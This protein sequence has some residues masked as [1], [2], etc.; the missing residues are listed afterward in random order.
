MKHKTAQLTPQQF[1]D[2]FDSVDM[3]LW[4]SRFTRVNNDG[5]VWDEVIGDYVDCQH[6]FDT[7]A[8][9]KFVVVFYKEQNAPFLGATLA[10]V[11]EFNSFAKTY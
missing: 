7:I 4:N 3:F 6:V 5:L 2:Q 10:D 8:T 11:N 9:W 1:S